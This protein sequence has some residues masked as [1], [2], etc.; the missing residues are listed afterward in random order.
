MHRF[1]FMDKLWILCRLKRHHKHTDKQQDI[2]NAKTKEEQ[3]VFEMAAD[4]VNTQTN[5][6]ESQEEAKEDTNTFSNSTNDGKLSIFAPNGTRHS[7]EP[8]IKN[9][10]K[11]K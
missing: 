11:N 4:A 8:I 3:G 2:E 5:K 10:A 7:L 1:L 9:K 6:Q